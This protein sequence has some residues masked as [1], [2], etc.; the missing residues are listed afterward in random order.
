VFVS[1][2]SDWV[3]KSSRMRCG[4]GARW[5]RRSMVWPAVI[6][7]EWGGGISCSVVVSIS[8]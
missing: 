8:V 5:E 7:V 4:I 6:E 3:M 2:K 1:R